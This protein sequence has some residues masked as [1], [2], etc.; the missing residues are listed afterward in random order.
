MSNEVATAKE[1]T[2]SI[3]GNTTPSAEI[4]KAAGATTRLD[5]L[6]IKFSPIMNLQN[7]KAITYAQVLLWLF[8]G[9]TSSSGKLC[10]MAK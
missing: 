8:C 9:A 3:G 4:F 10:E 6:D 7:P 5:G 2:P 1:K